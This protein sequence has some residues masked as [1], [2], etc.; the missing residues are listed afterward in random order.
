M[1]LSVSLDG[2][3]IMS[4]TD[5]AIPSGTV[6]VLSEGNQNSYFDTITVT[7]GHRA[8]APSPVKVTVEE[9]GM[10]D[11]YGIVLNSD[12]SSSVTVHVVDDAQATV[13]PSFVVL[14]AATGTMHNLLGSAFDD[15]IDEGTTTISYMSNF[16]RSEDT[17]YAGIPSTQ[18]LE[19]LAAADLQDASG[20]FSLGFCR[21]DRELPGTFDILAKPMLNTSEDQS[22]I[23][24]GRSRSH[25]DADLHIVRLACWSIRL[26]NKCPPCVGCIEC[27]SICMQLFVHRTDRT[28]Y[29]GIR[30]G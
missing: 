27:A 20:S 19:L 10:H 11:V 7:S 2:L 4:L 29:V 24:A 21:L 17:N 8:V 25:R 22:M 1:E 5:A 15:G 14:E 3:L 12:P 23:W 13:D 18:S 26:H 16:Q 6:G 28:R 30:V 9:G